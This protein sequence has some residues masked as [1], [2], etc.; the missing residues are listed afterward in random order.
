[1]VGACWQRHGYA[2]KV[3]GYE[4]A[5][6]AEEAGV[7]PR[8]VRYYQA[9]GLL[10]PPERIGRRVRYHGEHL[11][12]LR[13]ISELRERGLRLE[14]IREVLDASAHGQA[15]AVALLGPELA[16]ENWLA[17]AS[18]QF[19]AVEL[20]ELLGERQLHLVGDLEAADYLRRIET[21]EGVHWQCDDLPLM[22]GALE[23]AQ[24]GTDV[25]LSGDGRDLMRKRLRRLADDLVRIWA[26]EAG[27]RFVDDVSAE[28]LLPDLDR[29]RAIVW[30][31]AAH[32]MAQEIDRAVTNIDTLTAKP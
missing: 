27:K 1:M 21:D 4:L 17:E 16:S 11:T 3:M 14:S 15:P 13:Q 28:A 31:S 29:I 30:Q 7:T 26:A 25:T 2:D 23:L 9:N 32:I 20:A 18:R 5:T 12:R 19:N 24:L 6:L 8:T 22:L 10:P